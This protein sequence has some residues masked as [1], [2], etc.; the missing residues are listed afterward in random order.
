M[1]EGVTEDLV[2]KEMIFCSSIFSCMPLDASL[3]SAL[4]AESSVLALWPTRLLIQW[5][6]GDKVAGA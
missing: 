6:P 1:A 2:K 5:V 3:C 4:A